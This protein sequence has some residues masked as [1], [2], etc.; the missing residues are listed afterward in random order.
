MT[1]KEAATIVINE[2]SNTDRTTDVMGEQSENQIGKNDYI[3]QEQGNKI[4]ER[5]KKREQFNKSPL[6][7]LEKQQK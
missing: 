4:L 7:Q 6:E 1:L 5:I 3:T 2:F